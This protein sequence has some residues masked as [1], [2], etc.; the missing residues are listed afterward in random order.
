MYSYVA[1]ARLDKPFHHFLLVFIENITGCIQENNYLELLQV[2]IGETTR[3]FPEYYI[4]E[5]PYTHFL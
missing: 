4:K 5:I 2:I 3:I 1:F